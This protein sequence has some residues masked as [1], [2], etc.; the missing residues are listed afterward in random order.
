MQN[1][2]TSQTMMARNDLCK[3]KSKINIRGFVFLDYW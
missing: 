1:I 3:P 2:D